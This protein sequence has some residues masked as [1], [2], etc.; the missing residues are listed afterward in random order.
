MILDQAIGL[1]NIR[2]DLVAPADI[3]LAVKGRI[4]GI[5]ALLHF[6]IIEPRAQRLHGVGAV[7]VLGFFRGRDDDAG[8]EVGDPHGGVG[9][10]HMLATGA[11]GAADF[12][13]QVVGLDLDID[14]LGFREHGHGRGRARLE[15]HEL[16]EAAVRLDVDPQPV[17]GQGRARGGLAPDVEDVAPQLEGL[18]REGRGLGGAR[19]GLLHHEAGRGRELPLVALGVHRR[20]LPEGIPPVDGDVDPAVRR[21]DEHREFQAT[22]Y[23]GFAAQSRL[24]SG[25]TLFALDLDPPLPGLQHYQIRIYPHHDQLS[26][27]FETGC[28]IWL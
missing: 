15:H 26:H 12:D 10:V 14:L 21:E 27:R 28:M 23:F 9:G 6:Q 17:Q 1:K 7:L 16:V 13:P 2:A 3:G 4:G 18:H 11:A 19:G 20:H 22:D 24:D 25:E 5:L 8:G